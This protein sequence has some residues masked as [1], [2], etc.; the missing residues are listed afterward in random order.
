[1]IEKIL[2]IFVWSCLYWGDFL[3]TKKNFQLIKQKYPEAKFEDYEQNALATFL[4]KLIGLKYTSILL[5]LVGFSF[6][7]FFMNIFDLL[8]FGG[9]FIGMYLIIFL[10]HLQTFQHFKRRESEKRLGK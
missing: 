9:F 3:F 1:M 8:F 10:T 4:T 7:I 6:L 5:F 2:L